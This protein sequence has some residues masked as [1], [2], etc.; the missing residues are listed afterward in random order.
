MITISPPSTTSIF[1]S[2][3]TTT[4]STASTATSTLYSTSSIA[5]AA[6][7]GSYVGTSPPP[8][9]SGCLWEVSGSGSFTHSQTF[10]FTNMI[11]FP[12]ADLS[13]SNYG[14]EAGTA[15]HSQMYNSDQVSVGDGSL[16]LKVPG[17]QATSP[18]YGAEVQTT[19]R[20]ILYGSV[21]T[22]V[23]I[24]EVPGL[25]YYKDDNQESD[26]EILTADLASGA[27]YTNQATV[28]GEKSTTATHQLPSN[29]TMVMHEYRLDWLPGKTVYYLDGV[30][31]QV[32]TSNVPDS[33]GSWLWNNWR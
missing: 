19:I 2:S 23:Q 12:T 25:F 3:S 30:Q 13:I 15:P 33:P 10:D 14:V 7:G 32:L 26:I 29:A 18:I 28:P 27:H 8:V 24:S 6:T 9:Q 16:Q 4:S 11:D 1:G 31:Q 5:A 22:M 20:D 21:R 17:G